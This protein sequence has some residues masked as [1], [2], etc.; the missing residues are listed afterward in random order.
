VLRLHA[1]EPS[2]A[3]RRWG[4]MWQ[5]W[6]RK[7]SPLEPWS[8]DDSR[9]GN[10][11]VAPL[12]LGHWETWNVPELASFNGMVWYRTAVWVNAAQAKQ[13]ATLTLGT[14]DEV[15]MTWLNGR[16]LGSTSGAG[17]ERRYEIPAGTLRAGDNLIVVNAL[18]TYMTGGV[19]G[20][21][22]KRA[23][24]LADGTTVSLA[25]P[26]R[27]QIGP[28]S[29][30]PLPRAPWDAT[31]GLSIIHNAMIAPLVPYSLRG[32]LWYQGE[33]NTEDAANYERLLGRFMADWRAIFGRDLPFLVVQLAGYGPPATEPYESNW[34]ALREA[35][36]RAVA[37]DR[38]AALVVA[39]DIG[40]RT[41]VHPANKQEVGRR[42]ARA[43]RHLVYGES[44]PP[45]GPVARSAWREGSGVVVEFEDVTEQLIVYGGARPV[46]FELCAAAPKTCQFVDA[47][48][49]DNRVHLDA[50]QGLDVARV[51]YCWADSPVCTLYDR[52]GLPAGPFEVDVTSPTSSRLPAARREA[53]SANTETSQPAAHPE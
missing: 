17:T 38:N 14:I 47:S 7:S 35:Q 2:A 1:T 16:P 31:G 29:D 8:P 12:A 41:D 13:A 6:W 4:Q 49:K 5:D 43:A 36:R 44:I 30:T 28:T 50:P 53:A 26:W 33:S 21:A 32:V 27:Y 24:R 45:S 3:T 34:A 11:R 40:E 10:W 19:Y 48:V 46:G 20:P 25:G 42:L 52:S 23:L 18:D 39:I 37:G 22:E 51:R 9:T 15:D